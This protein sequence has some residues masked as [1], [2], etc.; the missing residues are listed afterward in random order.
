MSNENGPAA[1]GPALFLRVKDLVGLPEDYNLAVY[2][3][4]VLHHVK[5]MC[6]LRD[7]E[8]PK[9]FGT[10]VLTLRGKR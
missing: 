9:E 10:V 1:P 6:V 5:V 4:G 2:I 8:F 7:E 3:K